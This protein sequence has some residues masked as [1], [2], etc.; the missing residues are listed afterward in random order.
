MTTLTAAQ[1][2]LYET[3]LAEAETALHELRCGKQARVFVD[4]N[5]ERVEFA[6]AN[7]SRLQ[8]YVIE[9]KGLLGRN[10][11]L[12]GPMNSWML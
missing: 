3:R 1:R 5:G 10:T 11:G 12:V 7:S 9:L 4:Q 8:A 6:V 2:T